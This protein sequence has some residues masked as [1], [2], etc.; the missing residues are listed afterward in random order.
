MQKPSTVA[1]REFLDRINNLV[2]ESG[3]PAFVLIPVFREILGQLVR[4]EE[5]Q[6]AADKKIWD[7]Q[8]TSGNDESEEGS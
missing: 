6:Y 8:N 1:Y 7:E 4:N 5:V 2:N 3:L